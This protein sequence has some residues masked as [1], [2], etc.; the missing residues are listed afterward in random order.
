MANPF[1]V[2]SITEIQRQ[3]QAVLTRAASPGM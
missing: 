1:L 3:P 2:T